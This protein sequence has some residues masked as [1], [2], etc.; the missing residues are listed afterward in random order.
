MYW[1]TNWTQAYFKSFFP[2]KIL[3]LVLFKLHMN[4][5]NFLFEYKWNEPYLI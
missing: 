4:D 3:K 1:N 2:L 5:I